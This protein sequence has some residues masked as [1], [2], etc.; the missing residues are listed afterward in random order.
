MNNKALTNVV[1]FASKVVIE[2]KKR[3]HNIFHNHLIKINTESKFRAKINFIDLSTQEFLIIYIEI[4]R[5]KLLL[6]FA[7]LHKAEIAKKKTHS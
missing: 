5:N 1:F 7:I 6:W 4:P 3:V 2:E